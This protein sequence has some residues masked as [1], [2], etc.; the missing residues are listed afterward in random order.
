MD[1]IAKTTTP[2]ADDTIRL[3]IPAR[4]EHAHL[5][6]LTTASVAAR[7]AFSY[8]E[9][10][11]VRIAVGELCGV[12]VDDA[13]TS[14]IEFICRVTN[15]ALEIDACREPA[16]APIELDDLSRQILDAVTDEIQV[17]D[18]GTGLTVR[19]HRRG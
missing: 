8:D 11:D 4:A 15:D 1:P 2:E 17:H 10:E 6:R 7:L 5:A 3:N 16:G 14:R 13:P 12:L 18:H 19:K 9:V